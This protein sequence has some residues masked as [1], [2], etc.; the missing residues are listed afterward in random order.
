MVRIVRAIVASILLSTVIAGRAASR[1]PVIDMHVHS[2]TTTPD[3]LAQL[4][5]MNVRY[6][7]LAGLAADLVAWAGAADPN[8]YLPALVF[9]CDRGRA[10]ITGRACFEG[11]TDVPDVTWL[12]EELRSGRVR[13]FGEMSPQYLG[14]SPGDA[15]L[16]PYWELAEQFDIPV[17]VHMGPGPPGAAYAS[18]PVPFKSPAF[19]MALG[20]PL[21]LEEVLLR[22]KR[23]RLFVM[24]AGWPRLESMVALLYAHPNVY[25]DV[26][27]LQSR[28]LV[29]RSAYY[30]YLRGLVEA[31]FSKRIMFGSDFPDQLGDGIDAILAA[32]FLSAEHKAD[33]LCGNAAR[34]L[35]LTL[36]VCAP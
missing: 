13:G 32:D 29:P 24:H 30:P 36:S 22:H 34:F 31:G 35:R 8:R 18:S 23:L 20:D 3:R 33:I 25:V 19:R 1:P 4:Q 16:D 6:V 10:P 14:I 7:F 12:G 28:A 27:T 15:R 21:V 26:A 9:P 17:G 2:T 11:V 5:A